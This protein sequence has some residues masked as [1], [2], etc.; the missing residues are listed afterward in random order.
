MGYELKGTVIKIFDTKQV[1]ER[2][3][4]REF[5]VETADNP[6]YPQ[7]VLM[8]LTGD[9]TTQ[10]DSIHV[11][12]EVRVEFSVRGRAWAGGSETKYYVSLDCWRIERVG[13]ARTA[14]STPPDDGQ[15]S[16]PF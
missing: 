5:V 12:D 13:A 14:P 16:I 3:T 1:S 4:K 7:P 6:K 9:K 11:G 10:L 8:Q 15:D 2:F